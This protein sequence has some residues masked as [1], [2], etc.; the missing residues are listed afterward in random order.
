MFSEFQKNQTG[1]KTKYAQNP[2][3][4][5]QSEYLSVF[6]VCRKPLM[7]TVTENGFSDDSVNENI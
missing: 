2:R 4:M 5:Q 1:V 3:S 6:F 7:A